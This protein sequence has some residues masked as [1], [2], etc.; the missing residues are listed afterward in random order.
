MLG[1]YVGPRIEAAF[2]SLSSAL[3]GGFLFLLIIVRGGVFL[4]HELTLFPFGS[5]LVLLLPKKD[6]S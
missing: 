6:R 4:P 1:G 2:Q 5:K 3:L